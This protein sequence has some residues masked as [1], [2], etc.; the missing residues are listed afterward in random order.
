MSSDKIYLS[1]EEQAFLTEM[2][3]I[4]NTQDAVE[5]FAEMMVEERANP[6]DLL[7]YLKKIIKKMEDK[8]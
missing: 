7:K 2:L 3:E 6:I 1:R 8:K 5:R 4:K